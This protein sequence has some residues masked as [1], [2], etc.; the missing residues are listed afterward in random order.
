[1]DALDGVDE[2]LEQYHRA[3]GDYTEQVGRLKRV[4]W[5]APRGEQCP[6]MNARSQS[7]CQASQRGQIG[8]T[9]ISLGPLYEPRH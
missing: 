8:C 6:P 5:H 9:G 1:M 2:L 7:N 3:L 4:H